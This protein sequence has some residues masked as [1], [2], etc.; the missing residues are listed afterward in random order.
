MSKEKAGAL[1]LLQQKPQWRYFLS[2]VITF[3][4]TPMSGFTL[5]TP[6]HDGK[7]LG[8][9]SVTPVCSPLPYLK[10]ASNCRPQVLLL[11][12]EKE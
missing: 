12:N 10:W 8:W 6:L 7:A 9:A 2:F 5:P 4:H 1:N 11:Q 3:C